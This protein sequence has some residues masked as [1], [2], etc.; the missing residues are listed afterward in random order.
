M[1][2]SDQDFAPKGQSFSTGCMSVPN[3]TRIFPHVFV[4]YISDKLEK[5]DTLEYVWRV[6][7]FK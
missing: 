6:Y 2:F 4:N 7:E 5:S 1:D 3:V